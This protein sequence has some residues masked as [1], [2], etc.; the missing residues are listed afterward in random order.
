MLDLFVCALRVALGHASGVC[1]NCPIRE[2]RALL[3][4]SGDFG[5]PPQEDRPSGDPRMR[6]R[7]V[8]PGRDNDG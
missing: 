5:V 7:V 3:M 6:R 2:P 8:V 4:K 1:R